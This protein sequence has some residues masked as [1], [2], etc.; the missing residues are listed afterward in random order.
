MKVQGYIPK[1]LSG[2]LIRNSPGQYENG[3]D[4]RRHWN[5]GWAQV[6]RWEVNGE[7]G[8]IALEFYP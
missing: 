2:A 3:N 1:W 8:I 4:Q 6:H 5:D 7:K